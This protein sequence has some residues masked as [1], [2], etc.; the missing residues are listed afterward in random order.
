MNQKMVV[1]LKQL[2]K[3]EEAEGLVNLRKLTGP[4]AVEETLIQFLTQARGAATWAFNLYARQQ[5]TLELLKI[6]ALE[7]AE[8]KKIEEREKSGLN[9]EGEEHFFQIPEENGLEKEDDGK[10]MNFPEEILLKVF[11]YLDYQALCRLALVNR[12]WNRVANDQF[13]WKKLFLKRWL[14]L[15]NT[16]QHD[17]STPWK[18]EFCQLDRIERNRCCPI[19]TCEGRQT[20]GSVVPIIYGFPTSELIEATKRGMAKIGADHIPVSNWSLP[21]WGC[22]VCRSPW[23]EYPWL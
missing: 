1:Q 12:Q 5:I 15:S 8:L 19:S 2:S 3:K 14:R 17:D 23:K 11:S 16:W 18:R 10:S 6:K 9:N 7:E 20:E 22:K 21:I 13:L 4:F